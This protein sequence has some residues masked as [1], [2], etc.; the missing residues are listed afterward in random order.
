MC[1]HFQF[2]K[3]PGLADTSMGRGKFGNRLKLFPAPKSEGIVAC[4]VSYA[5][6]TAKVRLGTVYFSR[7]LRLEMGGTAASVCEK[8]NFQSGLRGHYRE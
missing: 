8:E 3:F 2:S 4:C 7:V 6:V 5:I 1:Q